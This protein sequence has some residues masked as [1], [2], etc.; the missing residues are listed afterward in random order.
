M[1]LLMM[2]PITY[3]LFL[4][5]SIHLNPPCITFIIIKILSY[6]HIFLHLHNFCL[7]NKTKNPFKDIGNFLGRLGSNPHTLIE[8]HD[9]KQMA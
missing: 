3:T 7:F 6:S 9:F 2:L 1:S 8:V 5:L 4:L